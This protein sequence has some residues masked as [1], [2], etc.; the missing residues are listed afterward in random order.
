METII[1]FNFSHAS[2]LG[3]MTSLRRPIVSNKR[4]SVF[5]QQR[6]RNDVMKSKM[7]ARGKFKSRNIFWLLVLLNV[8]LS[9]SSKTYNLGITRS[10]LCRTVFP[11]PMA[12]AKKVCRS[13]G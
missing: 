12:V 11:S 5:Q 7:A 4:A 13:N 8:T 2:I 3:F 6:Q 1:A 9:L 10:N